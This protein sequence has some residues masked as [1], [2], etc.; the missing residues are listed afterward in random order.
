M[1][2]TMKEENK[3]LEYK[4]TINVDIE[5]ISSKDLKMIKFKQHSNPP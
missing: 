2:V 1:V 5:N 3:T 4:E